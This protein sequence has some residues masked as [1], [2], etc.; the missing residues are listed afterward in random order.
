MRPYVYEAAFQAGLRLP[1]HP[2]IRRILAYYN[3][4]PA[5][6]AP[7][8]W[9]S[10][11]V[12]LVLWQFKKFA[13]SLNEF[14]HLFDLFNNPRPNSGWLYFKARP[15]QPPTEGYPNNVKG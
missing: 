3:I 9:Q 4:C 10:I 6:L 2:T 13:L 14:T 1:S 8:A 7:D 15:K 5:Q 12:V 11:V